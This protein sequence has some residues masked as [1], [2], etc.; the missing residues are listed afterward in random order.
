MAYNQFSCDASGAVTGW[1]NNCSVRIG[2]LAKP[3]ITEYDFEFATET[4]AKDPTQW[5]SD[6]IAGNIYPLPLI[7]E[8]DNNSE[9]ATLFTSSITGVQKVVKKG[10]TSETVRIEFDPCLHKRL[11]SFDGK[12]ARLI[13]VDTNN[14]VI[15]TSADGVKFKGLAVESFDLQNWT[16]SDGSNLSFTPFSYTYESNQERENEITTF[17]ADFAIKSLNGV[18]PATLTEV[19]S[20]ATDIVVTVAGS[21]DGVAITKLT[22]DDFIFVEADGTEEVIS[23]VVEDTLTPGKYTVSATAFVTGALH[24]YNQTDNV[25]VITVG[26]DYYKGSVAITI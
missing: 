8:M 23:G 7:E 13:W 25:Y 21:C 22:T 4:A 11:Q 3:F 24:L 12:K 17:E 15:G 19:S 10:K 20:T 1:S 9:G 6:I 26:S 14:N 18:Q 16:S 2:A 5:A